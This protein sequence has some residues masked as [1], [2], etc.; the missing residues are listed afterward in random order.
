[1]VQAPQANPEPTPPSLGGWETM[2]RVLERMG[3]FILI[4]YIMVFWMPKVNDQLQSQT[5]ALTQLTRAVERLEDR[6]KP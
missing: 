5:Q 2:V 4:A 3:S 1:M 6:I